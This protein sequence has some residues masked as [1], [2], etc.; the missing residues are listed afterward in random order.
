MDLFEQ[1]KNGQCAEAWQQLVDLRASIW[2]YPYKDIGE[3]IATETMNRVRSNLETIHQRLVGLGY[4]F[5]DYAFD[6]SLGDA[7]I[8]PGPP[9]DCAT[10]IESIEEKI[11]QLPLSLKAWFT[12]VKRSRW[13]NLAEV[14]QVYP[15]AD[16]VARYTVF[17]IKGNKY[18]IIT[19]IVYRSQTVFIVAIMTHAEY[20]L[21]KWKDE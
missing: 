3:K 20:D 13:H 11:G 7:E 18:R 14:K 1:Y 2:A 17:N 19:R 4:T 10:I 15:T 8:L 16:V 5:F 6:R 12:T 21:G 9:K